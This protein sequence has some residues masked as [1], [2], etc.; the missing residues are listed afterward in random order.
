MNNI[1]FD[2]HPEGGLIAVN[3]ETGTPIQKED[4]SFYTPAQYYKSI[5]RPVNQWTREEKVQ[6]ITDYGVDQFD[7]VLMEIKDRYDENDSRTW[8][9]TEKARFI[10]KHGLDKFREVLRR[11]R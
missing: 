10:S 11:R 8:T 4:G 7:R 1:K 5:N 6:F 3:R 2:K 9:S